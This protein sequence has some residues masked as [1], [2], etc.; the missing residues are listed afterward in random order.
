MSR[1]PADPKRFESVSKEE[2]ARLVAQPSESLD[3]ALERGR[4]DRMAAERA[5]K[6]PVVKSTLR[7]SG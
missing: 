5:A 1:D 6:P 7:F 2:F 4:Q 3:K